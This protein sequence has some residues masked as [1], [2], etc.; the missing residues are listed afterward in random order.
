MQCVDCIHGIQVPSWHYFHYSVFFASALTLSSS[1]QISFQPSL[2]SYFIY[3]LFCPTQR[4]SQVTR[5]RERSIGRGVVLETV[6]YTSYKGCPD[7]LAFECSEGQFLVPC[8]HLL[9]YSFC[10]PALLHHQQHPLSHFAQVSSR[11]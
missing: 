2:S 11:V 7:S 9:L 6:K 4:D 3:S 5:M 8:Q 10:S 1:S